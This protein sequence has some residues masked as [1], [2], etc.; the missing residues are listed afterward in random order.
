MVISEIIVSD[1]EIL[2]GVT[3]FAGTRVPTDT[4]LAHLKAGDTIDTFLIDFPSVRREQVEAFLELAVEL[5]SES[6]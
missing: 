6:I 3:V 2:D 1:K 4:L 5:L